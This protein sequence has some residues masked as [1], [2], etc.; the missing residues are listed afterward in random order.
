M[1]TWVGIEVNGFEIESYRNHHDT[2]FFRNNDRVRNIPPH[3]RGEFSQD[4]FIGYQASA[5]T[6]LRR[7]VLAGY[8]M[9]AC[10]LHFGEYLD[11]AISS[12]Q[13][14]IYLL[15]DSLD[16]NDAIGKCN[17]R[18]TQKI[19]VYQNFIDA[20]QNSTLEEWIELFPKAVRIMTDERRLYNPF[21]DVH[22]YNSSDIPLLCAMLSN[23][24]LYSEYSVTGSLNFP[25]NDPNIFTFAF[26]SSCQNDAICE[27]NIA[28]LIWSGSEEDFGDLEEIQK[29]TTV[30]FRN[31]L[32]S[33]NEFQQLSTLKSEDQVLQ[34]MCFSSIITALEAYIGD[35]MKREV[36]NNETLKRRFVEKSGV[37]TE[38][39][40]K[41][42]A[43]YNFLDGLDKRITEELDNTSFHNIQ[44][45]RKMLREV[46]LIEIPNNLVS[47]LNRAVIKRH[48]IVHRNGRSPN[49]QSINVTRENVMELINLVVQCIENIDQQV[50]DALTK[51]NDEN[52]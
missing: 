35:I 1:S 52:E 16:N 27:L 45:T 31:F 7:M 25:Y 8:D 2:W 36:L 44:T 49:G 12:A 14:I 38:Q 33:V 26:L 46:L 20:I 10:T 47:E 9:Q 43:I 18:Y 17:E 48:D 29:G 13:E 51:D 42:E 15:Q 30:P 24:P 6:I 40:M 21:N 50:L 28:E 39:K 22:W 3:Y 23:V 4:V 32:Q 34:R 11:K 5:A 19:A 37:F 41:V